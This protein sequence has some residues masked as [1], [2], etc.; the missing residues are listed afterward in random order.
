LRW[1][2]Y[3]VED[4]EVAVVCFG[5]TSRTVYEAVEEAEKK[6]VNVGYLRL[7]TL[8]PFPA[9]TVRRLAEHVEKIIVP[10]MNL[11]QI[12]YEVERAA[13]GKAEVVS[14]NKIGGGEMIFPEELLEEV[15][16]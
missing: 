8:W 3:N 5:C 1:K 12:F 2:A 9:E 15:V 4:C 11:K 14:V 6:G 7:K 13:C 10:E 16:P